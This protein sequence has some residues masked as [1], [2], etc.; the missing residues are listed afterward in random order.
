M[1]DPWPV[2]TKRVS[3]GG[4]DESECKKAR[5]KK[6][7]YALLLAYSGQGYLGLQR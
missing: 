1:N 3:E 2:S 6:K 5:I 7:M 4:E